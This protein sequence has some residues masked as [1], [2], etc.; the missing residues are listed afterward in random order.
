MPQME[1]TV[2]HSGPPIAYRIA[3]EA[4]H[5]PGCRVR[6]NIPFDMAEVSLYNRHVIRQFQ[7]FVRVSRRRIGRFQ[8]FSRVAGF[9]PAVVNQLVGT[10]L[11][12]RVVSAQPVDLVF[13]HEVRDQEDQKRHPV[14]VAFAEAKPLDKLGSEHDPLIVVSDSLD[15]EP[16]GGS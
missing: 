10:I 5:L 6:V 15:S 7:A 14:W 2:P 3:V 4:E 13:L 8:V 9:A 12:G 16:K 1:A 11:V